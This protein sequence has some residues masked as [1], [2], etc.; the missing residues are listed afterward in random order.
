MHVNKFRIVT[1]RS[2]FDEEGPNQTM[3]RIEAHLASARQLT[4]SPR[5]LSL[6][7]KHSIVIGGSSGIIE[8]ARALARASA[9]MN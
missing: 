3:K 2:T 5:A 8:S 6:G 7:G 9:S 1:L 4:K